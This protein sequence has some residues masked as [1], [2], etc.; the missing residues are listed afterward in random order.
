MAKNQLV[1]PATQQLADDLLRL[2][3]RVHIGR[4]NKVDPGSQSG[5]EDPATV[6]TVAIA[7][8]NRLT[9]CSTHCMPASRP[10]GGAGS[11]M[12]RLERRL[13]RK[14]KPHWTSTSSRFWKPIR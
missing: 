6:I 14:L 9:N 8:I 10:E 3:V 2:A 13:A 11:L 5:T 1:A 4:V 7:A 12:I